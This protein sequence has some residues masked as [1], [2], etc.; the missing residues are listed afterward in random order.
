MFVPANGSV[1]PPKTVSPWSSVEFGRIRLVYLV[2]NSWFSGGF[3]GN[4]RFV[5]VPSRYEEMVYAP[6]RTNLFPSA[7]GE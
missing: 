7:G 6:R 5:P 2:S 4:L 1:A 3:S